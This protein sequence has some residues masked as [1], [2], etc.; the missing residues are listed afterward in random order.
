MITNRIFENHNNEFSLEMLSKS[1]NSENKT[2][3]TQNLC[4]SRFLGWHFKLIK[5]KTLTQNITKAM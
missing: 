2:L 4:P 1:V 5:Y 3:F